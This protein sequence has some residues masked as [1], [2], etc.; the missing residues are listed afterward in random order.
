M[1]CGPAYITQDAVIFSGDLALRKATESNLQNLLHSNLLWLLL[2]S[3]SPPN[4][5]SDSLG[6]TAIKHND[7]CCERPLQQATAT[8][9]WQAPRA[10]KRE[11]EVHWLGSNPPEPSRRTVG[12]GSS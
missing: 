10:R 2:S 12:R 5:Q 6:Q 8:D 3:F 9:T 4:P 7:L 1:D 11:M